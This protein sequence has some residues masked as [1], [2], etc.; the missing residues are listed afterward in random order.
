M[1]ATPRV[2]AHT[3]A[4]HLRRLLLLLLLQLARERGA[5]GGARAP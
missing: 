1:S 4:A 3:H 5:A 2:A